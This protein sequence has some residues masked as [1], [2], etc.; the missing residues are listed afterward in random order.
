MS[1]AFHSMH[2]PLTSLHCGLE[3]ALQ[4]PRAEEEYRQRIGN[5]LESAGALMEM[6]MALRELTEATDPGERFGTVAL[7]P[8][9]AQMVDELSLVAEPAMVALSATQA[10]EVNIAADPM[11]LLRSMGNVLANMVGELEPGGG[12]KIGVTEQPEF[13]EIQ[14][15]RDG[16]K[17]KVDESRGLDARVKRIRFDAACSYIWT[18]EGECTKTQTSVE[19]KLPVSND[20]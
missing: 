19:I 3:L 7:G 5:A 1:D 6:T 16:K 2:Q 4:K 18:L 17:R 14:V 10:G 15:G 9:L 8:L 20:G 11:K 12:L 13:A